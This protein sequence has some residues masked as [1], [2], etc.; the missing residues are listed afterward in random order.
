M[1]SMATLG[2]IYYTIRKDIRGNWE[3]ATG[4]FLELNL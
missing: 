4:E 2:Q 1:F 3:D